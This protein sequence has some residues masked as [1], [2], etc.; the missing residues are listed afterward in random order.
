[1]ASFGIINYSA[2]SSK[3]SARGL[4]NFY[5][6]PIPR[7]SLQ[8]FTY[9]N[10]FKVVKSSAFILLFAGLD[11]RATSRVIPKDNVSSVRYKQLTGHFT[12]SK[13]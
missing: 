2:F 12:V 7:S 10:E 6:N 4:R 9:A 1:M 8:G 11:C 13:S 3:E 5:S